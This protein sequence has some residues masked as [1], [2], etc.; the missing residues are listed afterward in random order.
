MLLQFDGEIQISPDESIPSDCI[1]LLLV[2]GRCFGDT[3]LSALLLSRFPAMFMP[4]MVAAGPRL[5]FLLVNNLV[6]VD[7]CK[8]SLGEGDA[9]TL[10]FGE[11]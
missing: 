1:L 3:S 10:G 6:L 11:W 5:M 4:A 8:V 9:L 7:T 2:N